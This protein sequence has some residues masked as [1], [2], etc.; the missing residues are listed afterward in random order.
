VDR[1]NH[2]VIWSVYERPKNSSPDELHHV[3]D[4]IALAWI[5]IARVSNTV[6]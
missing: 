4:R 3:A 1:K 2:T 6:A 5:R